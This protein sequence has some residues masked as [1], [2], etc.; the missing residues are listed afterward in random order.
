MYEH[1]YPQILWRTSLF[2]SCIVDLFAKWACFTKVMHKLWV[3]STN[4]VVF[5]YLRMAVLFVIHMQWISPLIC[6]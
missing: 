1:V 2:W 5:M 4:S 6:L 3:T